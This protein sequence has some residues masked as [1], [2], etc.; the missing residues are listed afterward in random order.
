LHGLSSKTE[1]LVFLPKFDQN[2]IF[3]LFIKN[4]VMGRFKPTKMTREIDFRA[5]GG[6]ESLWTTGEIIG[7]SQAHY[8]FQN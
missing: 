3:Q 6:R 4:L 8:E 1:I 7:L 5:S 2:D